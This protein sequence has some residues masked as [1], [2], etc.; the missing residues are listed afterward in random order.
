MTKE[1]TLFQ[2]KILLAFGAYFLYIRYNNIRKSKKTYKKRNLQ[3]TSG[4]NPNWIPK[5]LI[6]TPF[7]RTEWNSFQLN[8]MK[9]SSVYQLMISSIVPR[10]IALISSINSKGIKN[11]APF[12]YFGLVSHDPPLVSIGICINSRSGTKKDTICNIEESKEFVINIISEWYVEA[13][14]HTCGNFPSDVDEIEV[15]GLT[16][17]ASIDVKPPRIAEAAIQMECKVRQTVII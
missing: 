9:S 16:P 5:Q 8:Q 12:S 1:D 6:E 3:Y 13:A 11:C 7:K 10:P 2:F 17:I 14:N 4:P 15:T